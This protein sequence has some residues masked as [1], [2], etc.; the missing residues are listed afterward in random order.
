MLSMSCITLWVYGGIMSY[1]NYTNDAIYELERQ[2]TCNYGADFEAEEE[3]QTCEECGTGGKSLFLINS[4]KVCEDCVCNIIRDALEDFEPFSAKY[5]I[6]AGE[7]F[8]NIIEDFTDS[9][10]LCYV[11]D[12]YERL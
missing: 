5:D 6:D 7:I 8:K 10:I 1:L 9:E 2:R 12:I 4:H 11:E 3:L